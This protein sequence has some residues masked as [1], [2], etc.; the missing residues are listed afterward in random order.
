MN[1]NCL[2]TF[3]D[4]FFIGQKRLITKICEYF[5]K[6]YQQLE[7]KS[8]ATAKDIDIKNSDS[9]NIKKTNSELEEVSGTP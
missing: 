1:L 2:K 4:N 7:R 9:K 8:Y 6:K 5:Q 3:V